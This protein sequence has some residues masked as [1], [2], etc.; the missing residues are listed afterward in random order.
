MWRIVGDT[1]KESLG[2]L[3]RKT[4]KR[5]IFDDSS[6][7]E[8]ENDVENLLLGLQSTMSKSSTSSSNIK[9]CLDTSFT[10]GTSCN[11]TDDNISDIESDDGFNSDD[12]N[13]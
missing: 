2:T 8:S 12:T 1:R 5:Y 11:G 4:S 13:I 7:E 9:R 6:D 10:S 3:G